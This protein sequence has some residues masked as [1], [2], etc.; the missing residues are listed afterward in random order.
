MIPPADAVK[1]HSTNRI[2]SNQ[3]NSRP[4]VRGKFVFVG[5]EKF[6]V[7]G[8]TYGPLP[9]DAQGGQFGD[10]ES[11]R[12]DLIQ[13]AASGINTIRT[14]T[15][16]PGWFLDLAWENRLRIMVSLPWEQHI[17]FLD[18]SLRVESIKDKIRLGVRACAAH[19]AILCYAIGNEIPARIVRWYGARRIERF[20]KTLYRVAKTEDPTGL[21][22]YVNY[23]ST[24]YLRLPFLD[25]VCFNV[26]LEAKDALD[27]YLA[28][29][30]N[31]AGD[32]PLLLTEIG[33]DSRRNGEQAQADSL[34]W[35]VRTVFENGCAGA[36]VFAWTDEWHRGGFDIE[37]W[38][39]GLVT[40]DREPK[41]ALAA[42]RKAFAEVPFKKNVEMP[43]ISVVVCSYNG[44][45]TIRDCFDGLR[46]LDYPNYEVIVV[47]DGSQD[48][49][50]VITTE[51]GFR[52][53]NTENRG[54]SSARNT[55]AEAATGEI[56]AYIDDDAYPD[57]QW[58][59]YLAATFRNPA[60][61]AVGGPNIAPPGDGAIAHCV[62]HSPGGPVHVLLNDR[63]A[64]HIP[65]CNMAFR[66][67][68]LMEIGGFDPRFRTAGDDVDVCW[69]IL[70]QGWKIGFNPA[71]MVWH[72]RRNSLRAYWR[73][74]KGYGRAEALL[75]AK[76]PEK[77]NSMGHFTWTGRLYG[78]GLTRALGFRRG[79]IYQGSWG[80]A[81]FQ[82][83]YEPASNGFTSLPLMPEWYLLI[84]ALALI[85]ALG[86]SWRPL[87]GA[88]PALTLAIIAVLFQAIRS[89]RQA[90]SRAHS[91]EKIQNAGSLGLIALLHLVQPL[92]RLIGRVRSGLTLWRRRGRVGIAGPWLRKFSIWSE[93]WHSNHEWL[94]AIESEL[95]RNGA[96]LRR[97]GDFDHWDLEVRGGLFGSARTLMGIEEHGGGKQLV[98]F[99]T[100]PAAS[101]IKL[102]PPFV[103]LALATGAALSQAPV[104]AVVVTLLFVMLLS[105]TLEEC[106]AAAGMILRVLDL[107]SK[108]IDIRVLDLEQPGRKV[109]TE[110]S[111]QD[112]FTTSADQVMSEAVLAEASDQAGVDR[113]ANVKAHP[114]PLAAAAAA[115]QRSSG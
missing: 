53:I 69:R 105:R 72:H 76:W 34:D 35:Q 73:Q 41:A 107:K 26:F 109:I 96:I 48:R 51:Y 100:W 6:Y 111:A 78:N 33:L 74:Q 62:A 21:V 82:S 75:E 101:P 90:A 102:V 61:G 54:L 88:V 29:L 27:A 43:R 8:V 68:A 97:G 32:Q 3:K 95:I 10:W 46:N 77:Y 22:T 13:I 57:P 23:P 28:R 86:F 50:A 113:K 110:S 9:P 52:L 108:G 30:Q 114:K 38:D 87:F 66:K 40:R 31:L 103:L 98:R 36:F 37:D 15:V 2:N 11:A 64:E 91:R 60:Y 19:P 58:L 59:S 106:A 63:D 49:T 18:D 17:S 5:D 115:G 44:A 112:L 67:S 83:I 92:A 65:G 71:A 4:R 42:V 84:S 55:G 94:A 1:S 25:F 24:E 20:L 85:S 99:R 45:R 81:L 56:V 39:F 7:R 80:A 89:A 79:R 12:R 104:A 70:D 16:P 14:Y 93:T 47:N